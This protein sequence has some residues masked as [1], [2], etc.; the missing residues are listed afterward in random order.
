MPDDPLVIRH[1]FNKEVIM[2]AE[3]LPN[4]RTVFTETDCTFG[5]DAVVLAAFAAPAHGR[6]CDLG[7]G[8]GIIPL[9]V[10]RDDITVDAVDC[11][12][13]AVALAR[14][15]VSFNHLDHCITVHEQS[16]SA[17]TL[18]VGQYDAVTCNPPYFPENCGK[19]SPD[20]ARRLAR[21][22]QGNTLAEVCTAAARLLKTGGHFVLCHRPERL[23]DVL[24]A[25]RACRLEPKRLQFVHGRE[26]AAPFLLLCDAVKGA[27]PSLKV[28]PPQIVSD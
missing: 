24:A 11:H 5:T 20:P 12:A 3:R 9:L 4:G 8:C 10:Q 2:G 25:L 23:T 1:F 26:N 16:W 28:L 18:P 7:C 17:L 22:E 14:R 13:P 6:V 19:H 27:R 21:H 15:S